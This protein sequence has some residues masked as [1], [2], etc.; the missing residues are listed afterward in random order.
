MCEIDRETDCP[1]CAG[2]GEIVTDWEEYLHP[3]KGAP[4]DHATAE[5][6]DCGGTGKID[7]EP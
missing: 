4:G 7:Y 6:P 5:C 1:R 3:P 2:N